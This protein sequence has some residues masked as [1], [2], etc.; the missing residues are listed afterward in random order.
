MQ[1]VLDR[2]R[3]LPIV[4]G[5]AVDPELLRGIDFG[6]HHRSATRDSAILSRPSIAGEQNGPAVRPLLLMLTTATTTIVVAMVATVFT[7]DMMHRE[8]SP[9]VRP[10]GAEQ[11][12]VKDAPTVALRAPEAPNVSIDGS[13]ETGIPL[14]RKAQ[15]DLM[16]ADPGNGD[17]NALPAPE[18]N[19][20]A[21]EITSAQ[22][23]PQALQERER[24]APQAEPQVRERENGKRRALVASGK[25]E[26]QAAM[27][28]VVEQGERTPGAGPQLRTGA[29]GV[30]DVL[31]GG[32]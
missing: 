1:R 26:R 29:V 17:V 9:K 4:P 32:L 23:L 25:R 3:Q 6:Q 5:I 21:T 16:A 13:K 24:A 11:A 30:G 7:L 31:S 14:V 22:E 12:H 19:M 20:P 27:R 2:V 8:P 28:T 15:P 10:A 18:A